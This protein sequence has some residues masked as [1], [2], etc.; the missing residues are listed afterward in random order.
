MLSSR[1]GNRSAGAA[2]LFMRLPFLVACGLMPA[3]TL[4]RVRLQL[5]RR[6]RAGIQDCYAVFVQTPL[7][8]RN[9]K[10]PLIGGRYAR[11]SRRTCLPNPDLHPMKKRLGTLS[12]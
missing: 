7:F 3:M 9:G 1:I 11:R 6:N 2:V 4:S 10:K 12:L 5:V 8:A